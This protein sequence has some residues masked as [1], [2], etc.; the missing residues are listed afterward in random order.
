MVI[1]YISYNLE[2]SSDDSNEK[3][4]GKKYLKRLI[5]YRS[6]GKVILKC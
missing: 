6:I 1:K 5:E 2:I 3:N 4:S